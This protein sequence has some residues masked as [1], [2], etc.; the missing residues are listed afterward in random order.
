MET[1][2]RSGAMGPLLAV[3]D[4]NAAVDNIVGGLVAR[5]VRCVR[6][7]PAAKA[8]ESLRHFSLEAQAEATP[9]GRKAAALRAA[10]VAKQEQLR[11]ADEAR[12]DLEKAEGALREAA[13]A[14]VAG[15]EVVVCTCTSAGDSLLEGRPWRCV[16]VDEAS[17][18]TEPSV[19]VALTRGAAFVVM[20]GDPRQLPP[21]V[22]SD[23][24]LE[25][26]L[27]VT[28]FERVAS[29]GVAPLLLDTQYRMHPLISAFPS[30]YFYGGKLRDGVAAADK[31]VPRGFA[32]PKPGVPLALVEVRGGQEETSGDVSEAAATAA[33][34]AATS[35]SVLQ[36][37]GPAAAA[38]A[39]AKAQAAASG[40]PKSG[41]RSSYRNPAEALAALAVTQKLLAGGDI[42]SAAILTPYRGQVRLVE[43]LLRQRGLD[44]AWAA[45]GREVAVSTVDGYQGR[46]ADVVVFSAVRAN[47]RGAVGFL[48][49]PRRM[50]VAITRPRRG[51]VVLADGPTLS[52]GSRDWATYIKWARQQGIVTD[53]GSVLGDL[54]AVLRGD[55]AAGVALSNTSNTSNQQG[56]A[57]ATAQPS[58][59]LREQR[60]QAVGAAAA[61]SSTT[62]AATQA[63][64]SE[65]AAGAAAKLKPRKRA[66]AARALPAAAAAIAAK[67][68][69]AALAALES[70]ELEEEEAVDAV[71]RTDAG[72]HVTAGDPHPQPHTCHDDGAASRTCCGCR[73]CCQ[74]RRRRR[75]IEA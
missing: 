26:G 35:A 53:D 15:A 2:G 19:L 42:S 38:A 55:G 66:A 67:A 47:E 73:R 10:A 27:G 6:L 41:D 57:T 63:E 68:R 48:S 28:L 1:G 51:L 30:A 64:D 20:A 74:Q 18:A 3:A 13:A 69:A 11:E 8:R 25:A 45:A 4:T 70:S 9:A 72:S 36:P 44:A 14:V 43:A 49:D 16:V 60:L 46:E 71:G 62:P 65:E 31:P 33:A 58:S 50:N 39:A 37:K 24:A 61:A 34:A 7:G 23:Q 54:E 56:P 5:G 22:L 17:Q 21:T 29:G 32:W 59:S 40:P 75:R 12:R 52:R